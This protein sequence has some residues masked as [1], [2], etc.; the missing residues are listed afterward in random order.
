VLKFDMLADYGSKPAP[1]RNS[2][3]YLLTEDAEL[4]NVYAGA[5]CA[6]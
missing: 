6:S 5:L 3:T 1:Y 2:L 4:W